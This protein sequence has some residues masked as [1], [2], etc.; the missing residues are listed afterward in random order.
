MI[1]FVRHGET[2]DNKNGIFSGKNN[3]QLTE[4]GKSQI[5]E[6]ANRL[7]E[8]NL[9]NATIFSSNL[10]RTMESSS[11]IKEILGITKDIIYEKLLNERDYGILTGEKHKDM[12]K[13][14]GKEQ[15][16]LWRNGIKD[17]PPGGESL[18][19]VVSRVELFYKK[20][21]NHRE[22]EEI[23]IVTHGNIIRAFLYFLGKSSEEEIEKNKIKNGEILF[24]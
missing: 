23:I 22:N 7:K 12:E 11:I 8:M 13:R 18:L 15:I 19:D 17:K 16:L 24:F 20:Y 3:S 9:K 14:F 4:G 6:T 21:L 5:L 2:H 1:I 10:N